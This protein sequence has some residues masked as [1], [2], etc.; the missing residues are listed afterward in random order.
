MGRPG[1][2]L[3]GALAD[4]AAVLAESREVAGL[5]EVTPEAFEVLRIEGG[6]PLFGRDLTAEN[7]PQEVARDAKA[8]NFVKGCYLGQETVAR[9][10]ALGHVN[11]LLRGLQLPG[12]V[13]PPAPGS[14]I[15]GDGKS[16]GTITSA[17]YSP[18]WGCVVAL[19]YLRRSHA[20]AGTTVRVVGQ[21]EGSPVEAVAR[22]LPMLPV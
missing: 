20:A 9:I 5:V 6:F 14:V 3:V 11:K 1:L 13:D 15:E 7:L 12:A 18:G 10:D 2:R 22:D 8:I 19:G 17:A 4:R 16:V 21:A